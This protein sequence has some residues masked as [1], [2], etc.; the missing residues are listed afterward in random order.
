MRPHAV[1]FDFDHTL[2]VDHR[3]E[4][5][6]LRDLSRRWCPVVLDDDAIAAVLR[7]FRRGDVGL[8]AMLAGAFARCSP[9]VGLVAAYKAEALARVGELVTP[10]PGC[11]AM[12]AALRDSGLKTAILSNGWTELQKAKAAFVGFDGPVLVSEEIGAWKPQLSAFAIAAERLGIDAAR[13]MYVG[14]SPTADVA[15][16]KGAGM[17]AVWA[18]LEG[19]AYPADVTPPDFTIGSLAELIDLPPLRRL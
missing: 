12:L 5:G 17:I 7:R 3:L 2:G 11:A 18:G 16:S 10:F 1:L 14:D 8:A 13:C 4:E 9:P 19:Q 6:V 15:G